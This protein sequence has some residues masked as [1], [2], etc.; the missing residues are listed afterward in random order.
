MRAYVVGAEKRRPVL[1]I[2]QRR[3]F[4]AFPAYA[5]N[6]IFILP[7]IGSVPIGGEVFISRNVFR[8]RFLSFDGAGGD[9][10]DDIA[11]EEDVHEQHRQDGE[12][13]EH[14]DLAEVKF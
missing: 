4:C 11:R 14:I 13:D 2:L 9:A 1:N 5:K 7:P 12:Q 6:R 10:F 3:R 8:M